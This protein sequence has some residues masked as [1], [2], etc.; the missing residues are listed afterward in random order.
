M[1]IEEPHEIINWGHPLTGAC[2]DTA[3][4]LVAEGPWGAVDDATEP[5][6]RRRLHAPSPTST[7]T[8]RSSGWPRRGWRVAVSVIVMALLLFAVVTM[9]IASLFFVLRFSWLYLALLGF[10]APGAARELAWGWLVGMF[11]DLATVAGM[12]FVISY[13]MLGMSAFLNA[14]RPRP[15]PNASP[16]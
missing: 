5:D 9:L 6:G 1:L 8:R 2:H 11:K 4:Q 14:A 16:S 12:S 7:T 13:L 3:R 15:S 10:Q